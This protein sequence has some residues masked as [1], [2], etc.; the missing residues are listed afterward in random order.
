LTLPLS[1]SGTEA[2]REGHGTGPWVKELKGN[3]KLAVELEGYTDPIGNAEYNVQLSQHRVEAVR[4]FLVTQGVEQLRI[5]SIGLGPLLDPATP[6]EKK[7]RVTV[8]LMLTE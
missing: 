2:R 4:R 5:L 7:R 6:N 1:D 3:E 8:K